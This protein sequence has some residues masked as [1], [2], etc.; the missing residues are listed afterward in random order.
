MTDSIPTTSAERARPERVAPRWH[1]IVL[2]AFLLLVALAGARLQSRPTSGPDVVPRHQ[3][4]VPLYLSTMALEWVL[5]GYVWLGVRRRVRLSDL[6][7]GRWSRCR[8]VLR[9]LVVAALFWGVFWA[10][11]RGL[12]GLLGPDSAKS[13]DIL[14][15]RGALEIGL[16]LLVAASAGFCEEL[17]FR[18]YLQRQFHAWTGSAPVA[19]AAQAVVFGVSHGYQGLK[20]VVVITALGALFGVL[21][22][23]RESLR[24]GMLAHA[25]NDVASGILFPGS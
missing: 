13:I 4:V 8:D 9:D 22:W 11:G 25:W 23:W 16:W 10:T 24:P 5:A 14:L 6:V 20:L 2:V 19:V 3:G 18:G 15:P 1:T 21:A 17:V 7:G 12:H